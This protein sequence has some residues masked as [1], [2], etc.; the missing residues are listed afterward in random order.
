MLV[1]LLLVTFLAVLMTFV[2]LLAF[3]EM[4]FMVI[5]EM[6]TLVF[7]SSFIKVSLKKVFFF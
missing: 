4:T 7:F 2:T 3:F 5:L 6:M 1:T